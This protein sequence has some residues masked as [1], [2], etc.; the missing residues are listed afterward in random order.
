MFLSDETKNL[1]FE[2]YGVTYTVETIVT[3]GYN[4]AAISFTFDAGNTV[5]TRLLKAINILDADE[6]MAQRV[7]EIMKEYKEIALDFS[8]IER[9]GYRM[10][11]K[12]NLR[13]IY[14]ALY[15]Y[16]GII[17]NMNKRDKIIP[18]A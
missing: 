17:I 18:L 1:L 16:T 8:P 11:P 6:S 2:I 3:E 14:T 4:S 10:N 15:P 9:D 12:V 7:T 13:R 5:R